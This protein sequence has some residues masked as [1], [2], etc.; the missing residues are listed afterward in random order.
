MEVSLFG[1]GYGECVVLH[2]GH[3][4]WVIID[5]CISAAASDPAPIHYLASIGV[6]PDL[7]VGLVVATHWHDDHIRGMERLTGLAKEVYMTAP[8]RSAAPR[9]PPQVRR[10]VR[11]ATRSFSIAD[12]D[13]GHVRIRAD[14]AASE[15]H[16]RCDLFGTALR[17]PS[18][19]PTTAGAPNAAPVGS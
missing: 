11:E 6:D 16:W 4:E 19:G 7:E 18:S 9:L 2:L 1:P 12:P 14:L 10:A 8:T 15:L 17:V 5:S 13:F 3:G